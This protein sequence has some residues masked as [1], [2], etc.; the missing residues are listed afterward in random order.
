MER[1]L[2]CYDCGLEFD[3][4]LCYSEHAAGKEHQQQVAAAFQTAPHDGEV[5]LPPFSL[6]CVSDPRTYPV[7]GLQL[8]SLCISTERSDLSFYLCHAC[9]EKC[10]SDVI[11]THLKSTEHYFSVFAYLNPEQLYFGWFRPPSTIPGLKAK[12]EVEEKAHG[13]GV[14]GVIDMPKKV[15]ENIRTMPY[16]QTMKLLTETEKLKEVYRVHQPRR[17][18]VQEYLRNPARTHPI[19]GLN[20]LVEYRRKDDSKQCGYL[21]LLCKKRVRK[22]LTIAHIISFDHLYWYL[23]RVH[24]SSLHMK[25]RYT[26]GGN[27]SVLI[28]EL[29]Q[30]ASE[31]NASGEVLEIELKAEDFT[32]VNSGSYANAQDLL[33]VIHKEQSQSD[34]LPKITPARKLF[35]SQEMSQNQA[36]A[37]EP[38]PASKKTDLESTGHSTVVAQQGRLACL[39]CAPGALFFT[40]MDYKKHVRGCKHKM[41]KESLFRTELYNTRVPVP[42]IVVYEYMMNPY[43][44]EPIIGLNLVTACIKT[45]GADSPIYLCHI[46]QDKCRSKI[47]NAHL[48]SYDHYLL[49]LAFLDPEALHFGWIQSQ[50]MLP[51]L[52]PQVREVEKRQGT[53]LLQVLDM[54][55]TWFKRIMAVPYTAVV[56]EL[57]QDEELKERIRVRK[58]TKLEQYHGDSNRKYPL[59]GLNFLVEYRWTESNKLCGYLCLLCKKAVREPVI[60]AH[61]IGFQHVFN[62]LDLA[63]PGSLG[64]KSLYKHYDAQHG[65]MMLDLA[66]QAEK[67]DSFG[68]VQEIKL[69]LVTYERVDSSLFSDGSLKRSPCPDDSWTKRSLEEEQVSEIQFALVTLTPGP[70]LV[71]KAS[72]PVLFPESKRVAPSSDPGHLAQTSEPKSLVQSS[73]PKEPRQSSQKLSDNMKDVERQEPVIGIG[74]PEE[75][76]M[77][78][79]LGSYL[80]NKLRRA[81]VI[82]LSSLT[83]YCGNNEANHLEC[84]TCSRTI[85]VYGVIGHVIGPTHQYKYIRSVHPELLKGWSQNP[86]MSNN[87]QKLR[88][89]AAHVEKKEGCGQF[90]VIKSEDGSAEQTGPI[91]SSKERS[92]QNSAVLMPPQRSHNP[93][94]SLPPVAQKSIFL[95][96]YDGNKKW[97]NL[98]I[99]GLREVMECT[100]LNQSPFYICKTCKTMNSKKSIIHHVSGIWHRAKY[101]GAESHARSRLLQVTGAGRGGLGGAEALATPSGSCGRAAAGRRPCRGA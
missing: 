41:R 59:L 63:H 6:A 26:Y 95:N 84:I 99:I 56:K 69:D 39:V 62:Y 11:L 87:S 35:F 37:L 27:Y 75:T 97:K 44:E 40:M 76:Q 60:I 16:S 100:A 14:L 12:A 49:S 85:P 52:L 98:S 31:I 79:L 15:F 94:A 101:L 67:I 61:V 9:H 45:D 82:G 38:V 96:N 46:C 3:N 47:I 7:I 77:S 22:T 34:L 80:K 70:R 78:K 1:R 88:T 10:Q 81:P 23:D 57:C 19:L 28:L 5:H 68:K 72:K 13:T 24:P 91:L 36:P 42:S 32:E 17:T 21:C 92:V 33:K 54:P 66:T 20:F 89:L 18:T 2:L 58:W 8:M 48:A 30:Q 29:A 73:S 55:P 93:V 4:F 83:E 86:S 25:S 53:G 50:S 43:R 74:Q 64:S 71:P 90:K 65:A 51:Y